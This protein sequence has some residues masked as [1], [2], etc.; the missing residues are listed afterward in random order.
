[1]SPEQEGRDAAEEYRQQHHLGTQPLGDL[2]AL[3][4]LEEG[5]DVAV[6]RSPADDAHGITVRDPHTGTTM[7]IVTAT[8]NPTR[9]RSTIA[10][11]LGHHLFGDKTPDGNDW[12]SRVSQESRA[13][14][15]ARHLL[16]PVAALGD[17]LGE[18]DTSRP[19]RESDVSALVQRFNLSPQMVAIQLGEA[20]FIGEEQ[21]E[22]WMRLRTPDL[23]TRY[24]WGG[25]YAL[26]Q[27]DSRATRPPQR[28][29]QRAIDG[30]AQ[31]L[32]S[33][34][35]IA[36]LEDLDAKATLAALTEAGIV[37]EP[38]VAEAADVA[39]L[40]GAHVQDPLAAYDAEF[41]VDG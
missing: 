34:D 35:T 29:L 41:G 10:H 3:I 26:W 12:N 1:M 8:D 31:G 37:V 9:L 33:I 4:D 30:Y 28:L 25:P 14:A 39:D 38:T 13:T 22:R 16:L 6:I 24:G 23:A 5:I 27:A 20:R 7:L 15:F 40:P 18:P 17:L 11:E 36:R 2:I 21:R 32:V 19:I